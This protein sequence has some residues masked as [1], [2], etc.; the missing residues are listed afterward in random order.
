MAEATGSACQILLV[1]D[2]EDNREIYSLYLRHS[3]CQVETAVDGEDALAKV[4]RFRPKVI[5]M[6]MSLPRMDGWEATRRLKADPATRHIPVIA[7][8]A[9]V[10]PELKRKA[11]EA[12]V[13]AYLIKPLAPG[14]LLQELKKFL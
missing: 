12:G 13:N 10:L 8:S 6:D 11:I 4:A 9:H 5:I 3:G 7:L 1:D 2:E 14:D